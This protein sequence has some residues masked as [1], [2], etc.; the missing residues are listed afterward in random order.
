MAEIVVNG[1]KFKIKGNEPTPKEQLAIDTY[2]GAKQL[3]QGNKDGLSFDEE[4]EFQLTPDEILSDAQK[5]KYNKDTESFLKSPS[6]KRIVAEVGL[7]IAGGLAGAAMAPFSGGSSLA[8]TATMAARVARLARP[9]LNISS[10]TVG[11]IGRAT[12]GAAAGGGVG[13]AISQTFDPRESIVK[14]VAR[15]AFQGGFGE[16][17]GYGL[18]GGLAKVYNKVT[19]KGL[20]TISGAREASKVIERD[21][22]FFKYLKEADEGKEVPKNVFEKGFKT[23]SELPLTGEQLQILKDPK[24]RKEIIQNIKDKRGTE[25]FADIEKANITPG[26]MTQNSTI[27]LMEGIAA[28]AI[29]GSGSIRAAQEMGK[30]SVM[31]GIDAFTDVALRGLGDVD[32]TGYAVGVLL[33]ESANANKQL[34]MGTKARLWDDLGNKVDQLIKRADG[35]YDP[36]YDIIL[37]GPNAAP[38]IQAYDARFQKVLPASNIEDYAL[39]TLEDLK[40]AKIDDPDITKMLGQVLALGNR[41]NYNAL[42]RQYSFL[43][44]Q[45]FQGEAQSVQAELLKRM[46]ALLSDAPLPPALMKE[47]KVVKEFTRMGTRSFNNKLM[48]NILTT[49]RGQEAL[50]KQIVAANKPDYTKYFMDIIDRKVQLPNGK[51]YP[52]FQNANEVK[53]GLRG[54]FLKNFFNASQKEVGQYNVLDAAQAAK[55]LRQHKHILDDPNFLTAS[56]K[57][58]LD[59]YAKALKFTTGKVTAPGAA[60]EGTGKIFIQ[61]KQAGAVT[62]IGGLLLG[63]GGYIDPGSAA[64]FVLAP[65][66]V[67]KAFSSPAITRL[68]ID[69]LGGKGKTIDSFAKYNRFMTQLSSGLVGQGFVGAED[70]KAVLDDIQANKDKYDKFFETGVFDGPVFRDSRPEEAPALETEEEI[71]RKQQAQRRPDIPLPEVVP[72]NLPITGTGEQTPQDRAQLAQALNLFG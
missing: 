17:L 45:K 13:A 37:G 31:E 14:E 20:H 41:T 18:A 62:Q 16:V 22:E 36:N 30:Q 29:A 67:A 25:F 33:N 4:L 7:S 40:N 32:D 1:Q 3:K 10:K 9:L 53:D 63:G 12:A 8:L 6:F 65:Y 59:D 43:G 66:G 46:E 42:R 44:A 61:L 23:K 11:K 58:N 54:Q 55:F 72:A 69:G 21:K 34:F 60:G 51:M 15:G 5:G 49:D 56:Q 39:K 64:F 50:Y 26:V 19:T 71:R 47:A 52:L 35:T 57:K 28:S 24:L 38:K 68:L 2:I 70:A 27:D 48:N